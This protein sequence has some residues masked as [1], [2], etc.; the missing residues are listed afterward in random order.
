GPVGRPPPSYGRLAS[1]RPLK[2]L[3]RSPGRPSRLPSKRRPPGR[4]SSR[5]PR[6]SRSGNRRSPWPPPAWRAPGRFS[7]P[8]RESRAPGKRPSRRSPPCPPRAPPRGAPGRPPLRSSRGPP[9]RLSRLSPERP[10]RVSDRRSSA[11][12]NGRPGLRASRL[13]R[14]SRSSPFPPPERPRGD[15]SRGPPPL[16]SRGPPG[17]PR[18]PPLPRGGVSRLPFS[19]RR[20]RL[21][22]PRPSS[23]ALITSV[24][25]LEGVDSWTLA[26]YFAPP[27]QASRAA[28]INRSDPRPIQV[29]RRPTLPH[30]LPCSTIGAEELNYRVR[31]G[32]GCFPFAKTTERP[33][34]K[35]PPTSRR[36]GNPSF[37][38]QQPQARPD[39]CFLR[40]TQGREHHTATHQNRIM[41]QA[42]RPIS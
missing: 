32:T 27:R 29:R 36:Q 26:A 11:R 17:P 20:S 41:C 38:Y 16:R 15:P 1:P 39:S 9:G 19:P 13:P 5:P 3:S 35:H 6:P 22:S 33:T 18:G 24:T 23:S 30:S 12:L 25:V 31:N 28:P 4:R 34:P 7:R 21:S 8:G 37:T 2:G 14:G 42:T 40:T 10:S